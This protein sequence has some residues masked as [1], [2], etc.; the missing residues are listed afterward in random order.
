MILSAKAGE[1]EPRE[2][3]TSSKVAIEARREPVAHEFPRP[4]GKGKQMEKVVS[5]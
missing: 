1:T 2:K 3:V 4:A 5:P